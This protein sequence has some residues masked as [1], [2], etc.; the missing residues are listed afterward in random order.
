MRKP[1]ATPAKY[2]CLQVTASPTVRTSKAAKVK[3]IK[4]SDPIWPIEVTAAG[5]T[6]AFTNEAARE[7][8]R[9][10]QRALAGA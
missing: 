6:L 1:V 4:L 8:L 10:L 9:D 2:R 7:L 5:V 3:R